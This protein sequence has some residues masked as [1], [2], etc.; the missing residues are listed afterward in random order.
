MSN[1]LFQGIVHQM[2]DVVGRQVGVID[3]SAIIISC[4]DLSRLGEVNDNVALLLGDGEDLVDERA[5]KVV[6]HKV[7]ADA[8]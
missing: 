1:R 4:S 6:W 3:D 2:K 8:L 7:R 5:V